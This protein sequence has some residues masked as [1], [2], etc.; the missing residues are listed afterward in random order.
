MPALPIGIVE[1]LQSFKGLAHRMEWLGE[2]DRVRVI[3]NS[4]CTN[5][6]AV[7][8]SAMA[9]RDPSHLLIGGVNKGLDFGPLRHYLAN[10]RHRAY[11]FGSDAANLDAML[12]GGHPTFR[13]LQEA[14]AAATDKAVPGEVIML[15]PGCA[16]TDQFRDFRERGDVFR[17]VAKEWLNR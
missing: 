15:A 13:T 9:V 12:G 7:I 5:P 3:N 14:F 11:L 17:D 6:D 10:H 4:M 16:S 2:R 8:K 1:G